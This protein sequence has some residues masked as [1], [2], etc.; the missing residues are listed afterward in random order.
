MQII[1]ATGCLQIMLPL[2]VCLVHNCRSEKNTNSTRKT[3]YYKTDH[4]LRS[5]S[6][7]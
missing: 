7:V 3:E 1:I 6:R 2:F 4:A 5:Q